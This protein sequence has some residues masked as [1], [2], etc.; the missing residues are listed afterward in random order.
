MR[1]PWEAKWLPGYRIIR[2][3]GKADRTQGVTLESPDGF[4]EWVNMSHIRFLHVKTSLD[5][6]Q[7][8]PVWK[9]MEVCKP[10]SP[11]WMT[12][13]WHYFCI[14]KILKRRFH[15]GQ[16]ISR[17]TSTYE[18]LPGKQQSHENNTL[19]KHIESTN[20]TSGHRYDIG[21]CN[22]ATG[23]ERKEM[24]ENVVPLTK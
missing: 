1:K 11:E 9:S 4:H 13:M 10:P 16:L 2:F 19:K 21:P 14:N 8:P 18:R 24:N 17:S 7:M 20:L 22:R 12:W 6:Y 5:R 3:H 15:Q 23:D